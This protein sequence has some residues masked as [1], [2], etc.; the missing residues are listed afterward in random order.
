MKI[1]VLLCLNLI[2]AQS[3][4]HASESAPS[5]TQ[6]SVQTSQDKSIPSTPSTSPQQEC[7]RPS[8]ED[9]SALDEDPFSM[10]S[11][12]DCHPHMSSSAMSNLA[13]DNRYATLLIQTPESPK[14]EPSSPRTTIAATISF[15]ANRCTHLA[16]VALNPDPKVT[17]R[18]RIKA[19]RQTITELIK[20]KQI[21]E[22]TLTQTGTELEKLIEQTLQQ[23]NFKQKEKF[24]EFCKPLFSQDTRYQQL[25]SIN[26]VP[27]ETEE[28]Q[29]QL[30]DLFSEDELVQYFRQDKES[31]HHYA[32]RYQSVL[33]YN[34]EKTLIGAM[35]YSLRKLPQ[36]IIEFMIV[37]QNHRHQHY[38]SAMLAHV[39]Q[40]IHHHHDN[41]TQLRIAALADNQNALACYAKNGFKETNPIIRLQRQPTPAPE[42][43]PLATDIVSAV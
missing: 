14:K 31:L 2:S 18:Q 33:A 12:Q 1:Y 40:Y 24:I 29:K 30:A 26:L 25:P 28:Q 15:D 21:I 22:Y 38:G 9:L 5:S 43:L 6:S 35:I 20:T 11:S 10:V 3:L 13:R 8:C 16:A 32:K 34:A 41:V 7:V 37:E 27:A 19:L 17:T 39:Q 23:Q 4:L 36:A 42:L